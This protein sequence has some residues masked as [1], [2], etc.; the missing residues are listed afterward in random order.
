MVSKSHTSPLIFVSAALTYLYTMPPRKK[1]SR[2]SAPAPIGPQRPINPC[3]ESS[4]G[5]EI[6]IAPA[7]FNMLPEAILESGSQVVPAAQSPAPVCLP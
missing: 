2:G 6:P 3:I 7:F 1:G 4:D 5:A